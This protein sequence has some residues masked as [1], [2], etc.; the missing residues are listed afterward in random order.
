MRD[1]PTAATLL[2]PWAFDLPDALIAREPAPEREQSRLYVFGEPPA[3]FCDLP[4]LLRAGDVLVLNDVQ[5]FRARLR[6]HRT[7]GG[8]VEVLIAAPDGDGFRAFVRPGRRLQEGE[9]LRCGAGEVILRACHADGTWTVAADPDVDTLARTAGEVPL[10]PYLRRAPTAQDE[11]RYQTVYAVAGGLRASA[12]PTAGLHFTEALLA[13]IAAMGVAV[14]RVALEVGAGTFQPLDAETWAR[15]RLHTERYNVP[16]ETYLAVRK[17]KGEGRRVVA[18]GTTVLRVLESMGGAGPST[19]DLFVRPGFR[20]QVVD[21]LLTNF[22]LP[23]S[24]LL[25]LVSTFGG[26][27]RVMAGYRDAVGQGF[28]FYSY[29]DAMWVGAVGRP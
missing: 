3:M 23:C 11:A 26:H 27:E 18:V 8:A 12:A 15:G 24:S 14:H 25:V 5:V 19:T 22:H 29:G 10:P 2:A 9:R 4:R 28:R 1:D 7:S 6:A 16:L 20:F 17:A 13:R 21:A